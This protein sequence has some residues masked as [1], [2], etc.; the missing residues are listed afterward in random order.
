MEDTSATSSRTV[1]PASKHPYKL[2]REKGGYLEPFLS[3]EFTGLKDAHNM[4]RQSFPEAYQHVDVIAL[5][6]D[7]LVEKKEMAGERVRFYRIK[8]EDAAD[9]D[10][11]TDFLLAE[12]L[13]KKR[14]AA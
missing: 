8:K 1:V 3:E 10:T 4:P 5:R 14:L 9:I 7:T 2:W 13:L 12:L 11:E 6:W